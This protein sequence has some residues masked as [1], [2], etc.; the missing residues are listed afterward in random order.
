MKNITRQLLSA[1]IVTLFLL[2]AIASKV[3]KIHYGA[4]NYNNM[5]EPA[6]EQGDYLELNDGTRIHGNKIK[7]KSGLL[8]KDQI[9]ADDQKFKITEVKGYYQGGIYYGRLGKEYIKRIVHGKLNVYVQFTEVTTTSTD[10]NGY[11]RTRTYTRTDH[12]VQQGDDGKMM[13]CAG[14][15]DIR[16]FV[17]DCPLSVEMANLSNSKMRKAIRKNGNYL[18]EIFEVY[19]NDCKPVR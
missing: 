7:W 1:A 5:V 15:E 16:K 18:N 9:Q 12:Y 10:N 17:A 6:S 13:G 2:M 14:Q 11:M 8:V 3:N 19:N 4:F